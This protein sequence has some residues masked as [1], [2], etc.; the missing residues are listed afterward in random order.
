ARD[1][2]DKARDRLRQR[3][4]DWLRADLAT[5]GRVLSNGPEQTR[6]LALGRLQHCLKD[7]DFAGV[8]EQQALAQLPESERQAWQQ[9]WAGAR[10]RLARA[11]GPATPKKEPATK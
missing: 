5:Y 3:A 8:R 7:P 6:P 11:R 10:D 9:L 4:L 1:L 2:D